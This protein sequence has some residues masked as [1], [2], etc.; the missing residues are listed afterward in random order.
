MR[1][2]LQ[3]ILFCLALASW[4]SALGFDFSDVQALAKERAARPYREPEHP[5]PP[6]LA[7][8]K[9]E[10]YQRISF[11]GSNALWFDDSLPFRVEFF[12]RGNFHVNRV[13][14]NEITDGKSAEIPFQKSF[15]DYGTNQIEI[16]PDL[17]YAGFRV[18]TT[19]KEP[20]EIAVFLDATYCRMIGT[21]QAYG[22]SARG[23]ALDTGL[24]G[25]EEFP[26]FD[27][28]W[29][30]RPNPTDKQLTIFALMDSP[31]AAGAY[32]YVITPGSDTVAVVTATLIQRKPVK[33]FGLAPLSSMFLHGKNGRPLW[34]DFRPEVHDSD[35]LLIKTGRGEW[36]WHPLEGGKMIR[37]N[38]FQDENPQGFGLI[39]RER[40]FEQFQDLQAFFHLRPNVW[41]QPRGKWGKGAVELVQLPSQIEFTDNVVAFWVPETLP[42]LGEAFD[43]EYE[44]HWTKVDPSD[45]QMGQVIASRVSRVRD[46]KNLRFV[47]DFGGH[48]MK[49]LSDREHLDLDLKFSPNVKFVADSVFKNGINETWRVVVEIQEPS[50]AADLRA[51]LKRNEKQTTETWTFTWQP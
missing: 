13:A 6:A 18:I 11:K 12:H 8:L 51:Y 31:S 40:N 36:I 44:L 50:E 19:G 47:I 28:F 29:I 23:L 30:S 46:T 10:A 15:F 26:L 49:G 9:Y 3:W 33:A 16:A 32:R 38:V 17:G 34:Q 20:Q 24:D 27:Q 14:L 4:P 37:F 43:F 5:L 48:R 45:P 35:G 21:D 22:T 42:A 41:I 2:H 25:K 7:D 1:K 39:Q